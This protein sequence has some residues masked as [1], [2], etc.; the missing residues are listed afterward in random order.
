MALELT[1]LALVQAYTGDSTL[2][3]GAL[4]PFMNA[5]EAMIAKACGRF[6]ASGN[7]WLSASHT[8][9]FD[10]EWSDAVRLNFTSVS[11]ITSVAQTTGPSSSITIA[12]T[13]LSIDGIAIADLSTSNRAHQ[14]ILALRYACGAPMSLSAFNAG[15][16]YPGY[17]NNGQNLGGGRK[18]IKVVYTGGYASAPA[19]LS[20]AATILAVTLYRRKSVNPTIQSE[21]LGRYSY[22]NKQGEDSREVFPPEVD[23]ILANY[24]SPL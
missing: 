8:E 2:T 5:A 3:S 15:L 6:D 22:T 19:D 20:L 18:R 23:A 1:T 11:A 13:D 24:R 10:G 14:G 7:H 17:L 21:T 9:Y 16:D 4:N 12:L